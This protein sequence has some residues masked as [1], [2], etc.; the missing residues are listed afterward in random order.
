MIADKIKNARTMSCIS[1]CYVWRCLIWEE[2]SNDEN[3][4]KGKKG[5]VS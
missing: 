4:S 2:A 5:K 1:K 3:I